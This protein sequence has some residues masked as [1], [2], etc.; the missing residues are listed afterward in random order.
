VTAAELILLAGQLIV[1][2]FQAYY[3]RGTLRA[4]KLAADA[5]KISAEAAIASAKA[6]QQSVEIA[7]MSVTSIERPYLLIDEV[8]PQVAEFIGGPLG[9]PTVPHAVVILKNFGRSP[10]L[11]LE[12]RASLELMQPNQDIPFLPVLALGN[13]VVV[14]PQAQWSRACHYQSSTSEGIKAQVDREQLHMWLLVSIRYE[15]MLGKEHQT[16]MRLRYMPSEDKFSMQTGD[17]YT[18]RT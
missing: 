9:Q 8:K 2:G 15:D 10:A 13:I 18:V 17:S 16:Q 7:E 5:T 3:L 6:A 11:L 4:T 14:G 12:L 1:L